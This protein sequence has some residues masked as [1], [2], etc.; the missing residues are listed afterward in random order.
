MNRSAAA[1][2]ASPMT[3][4]AGTPVPA[5]V[6]P[7]RVLVVYGT[8]P[9]A[10]Q[11]APLIQ[12]LARSPLFT[13]LVAVTG[14]P[15]DGVRE[16]GA[17][18]GVRPRFVLGTGRH[19]D[20]VADVTRHALSP[21]LDAQRPD[22]VVVPGA[23]AC[24]LDASLA[25]RY[26][27]I[28]VVHLAAGPR[29]D[30]GRP[31]GQAEVSRRLATRLA[32][33][34]L[35]ATAAAKASLLAGNVTPARVVVTGDTAIDA[36]LWTAGQRFGY[37]DPVLEGLD[38]D[39][40]PVLLAAVQPR[41][42]W[43]EPTQALARALVRIAGRFPGLRVVVPAAGALVRDGLLAAAGHLPNVTVT[44]PLPYRGFA[45]LMDRAK[46][47]LTDRADVPEQGPS[48]G[49]PVLV[50][51][52]TAVGPEAVRAGT[53]RLVGLDEAVI[54]NTVGQL[55]I[56]RDSY[57]GMAGAVNPYG[58]GQ[59]ASRSVAAIAHYFGVGPAAAE[60]GAGRCP[61]ALSGP[62]LATAARPAGRA[63][64]G[65]EASELGAGRPGGGPRPGD[66]P[67]GR[68]VGEP[69]SRHRCLSAGEGG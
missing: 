56:D 35:T 26:Q 9:E 32:A 39:A 24:V 20:A 41:E 22:A 69:H 34:H 1:S 59:A 29:G 7:R 23:G 65:Q 16:V 57:D 54:A 17:T 3:A 45:R 5:A 21:L 4:A 63:G 50:M 43:G 48:L 8:E 37:G 67:G 18:F 49:K 44:R 46:I 38:R 27:Q 53:A 36:L 47:I 58:D 68:R 6:P 28:P 42:S 62:P 30:G 31:P 12:A 25:A 33:L 60:F 40:V 52:G 15:G 14:P 55:L 2:A 11:A 66:R 64:S 61:V 13:P 10:L 51:S 19:G